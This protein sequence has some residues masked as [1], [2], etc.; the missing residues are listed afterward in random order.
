MGPPSLNSRG[1]DSSHITLAA[2]SALESVA[3]AA[4]G[5]GHIIARWNLPYH[6]SPSCC[7]RL[8][9]QG[10]QI[11]FCSP[12]PRVRGR[13]LGGEQFILF[14]PLSHGKLNT[15]FFSLRE[16]ATRC[17]GNVV[18][19]ILSQARRLLDL[20]LLSDQAGHGLNADSETRSNELLDTSATYFSCRH[21]ASPVFSVIGHYV[22][23]S[24]EQFTITRVHDRVPPG[25]L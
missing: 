25:P 12:P 13:F 22:H 6:A 23:V 19:G 18:V 4:E 7:S 10:C 15:I 8:P 14:S 17:T 16:L 20:V 24:I 3:V 11:R 21:A 9:H 5:A 2:P 1:F